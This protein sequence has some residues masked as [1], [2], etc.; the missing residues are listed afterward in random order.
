MGITQ[1]NTVFCQA[2]DLYKGVNPDTTYDWIRKYP[3]FSEKVTA[4]RTYSTCRAYCG[5]LGKRSIV[6]TIRSLT[7]R[8]M[9]LPTAHRKCASMYAWASTAWYSL[10]DRLRLGNALSAEHHLSEQTVIAQ[11]TEPGITPQLQVGLVDTSRF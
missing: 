4:A 9:N 1:L 6:G 8:A 7:R 3:C 10:G 11:T 2:N 5:P